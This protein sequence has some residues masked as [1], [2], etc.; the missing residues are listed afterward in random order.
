MQQRAYDAVGRPTCTAVRMN[1]AAFGSLPASACTL[2]AEGSQGPD[3]IERN[4]YDAAGQVLEVRRAVGTSLEQVYAAYTY[5]L[6]GKPTSVT[7]AN[8]NKASMTYDGF[9]RQVAWNFPSTTTPGQVSTTDYEAYGYDANGNRTSLRKRDGRVIEYTYDALNRMTSK[10]IPD[11]GGLPASA[12]RD[13]YYGYDL[14]GLQLYARFDSATGEGV[15]NSWD[16]LGRM[17]ASSLNMGGVTRTFSHLYDLNGARTR[18]FYP[19]GQSV[20]YN[21]DGLGRIHTAVMNG[22]DQLLHPQYDALGRAS[23]L[24]RLNGASWGSPTTYGY[25]GLSR[26]TSLTHDPVG[27][28]YDVTTGF[29]YNPASQVTSRT[30]SNE[31]YRFNDHVNVTRNYAVNGLNQYT[32]AG[33]ASFTYD[34]NGNLTADG[35]GGTYVYDVENRL[36]AGP[37]GASL[38]WDPLGRLFQSS[39]NSQAATRYLYDGDKLTAEYDGSG[40]LLRRYVHADGSDTPLVWYEGSGVTA[41]QYLYADHQGSITAR[42]NASGAVTNVNTYDEYGIPGAGNT[43]RF[44]YTGQ[45][46]LPE[47]A[48]YHYKARIYSPTLGRFLQTDPIGYEDQINL[49]AYVAN[50]PVSKSDPTGM[51]GNPLTEFAER[52][53]RRAIVDAARRAAVRQAWAMERKLV[54]QT[55]A[56]SREWTKSQT[57]E[58]LSTGRVRGFD[59][60]H[61]R[62]VQNHTADAGNPDNI[63]FLSRAEHAD[64]HRTTGGTRGT[65][66]GDLIDRSAGGTISHPPAAPSQT[67]LMQ[68]LAGTYTAVQV[69][70]LFDPIDVITNPDYGRIE[71][72]DEALAP[73]T[74]HPSVRY[75]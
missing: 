71:S 51:R 41:P 59:G 26:L 73:K 20:E 36:I 56:G 50:D 32:S 33:Q 21:R 37:N 48:M 55:G 29:G 57:R 25:D 27:T 22:S 58:L 70:S 13:V 3:R 30:V 31:A 7:D 5:S 74:C 8:G 24:Y 18:L 43:G 68:I 64:V 12:T 44:Q 6:N 19:D 65:T 49:Y 1:P 45:A 46:W 28:G 66:S 60:H 16:G 10:I 4:V 17:T 67:A 75:C 62:D 23:A 47:L 40:N 39:S 61:I 54:Q 63:R 34:A 15:T 9:D 11:G 14:R 72:L 35:Q 2:G 42:T 53:A 38:V 52:L 69:I